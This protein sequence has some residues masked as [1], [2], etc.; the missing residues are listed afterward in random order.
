M[1]GKALGI[2]FIIMTTVDTPYLFRWEEVQHM[3]WMKK[4]ANLLILFLI[5][6][7]FIMTSCFIPVQ[8]VRLSKLTSSQTLT[9][10]RFGHG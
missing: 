7:G 2:L 1:Y 8:N 3:L 4:Y 5:L 10:F 9:G 6:K